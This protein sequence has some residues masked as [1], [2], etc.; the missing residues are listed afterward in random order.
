MAVA[1][2]VL[3]TWLVIIIFSLIP[4]K[5]TELEM[6]ILFFV[7][8]IFE[9]SVFTIL[10]VNLKWLIVSQT[11]EKSFA[12]LVIRL[13]MIPFIFL[14]TTNI[15]L[16]SWKFLNWIIVAIIISSFLLLQILLENLGV[17]KTHHWNMFSTILLFCG[18]AI[19]SQLVA[20]LIVHVDLKEVNKV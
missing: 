11:V 7:N 4:K 8:T 10:H 18:Y 13:L 3:I 16:Y 2:C 20:W 9:L 15:L 1:V 14:I 5:L 19:F 6:V 17:L 12:D